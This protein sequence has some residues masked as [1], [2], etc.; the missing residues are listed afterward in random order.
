MPALLLP[1]SSAQIQPPSDGFSK[2]IHPYRSSDEG[3][4]LRSSS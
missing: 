2:N 4:L 1:E 3:F